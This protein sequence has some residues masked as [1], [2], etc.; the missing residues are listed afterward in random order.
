MEKHYRVFT[1]L[2][3]IVG[4]IFMLGGLVFLFIKD[5]MGQYGGIFRFA[6]CCCYVE[7]SVDTRQLFFLTLQGEQ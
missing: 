5:I 3:A 6:C 1:I 4:F 7:V 2:F